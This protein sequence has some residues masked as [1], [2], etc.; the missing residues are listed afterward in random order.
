L[1]LQLRASTIKLDEYGVPVAELDGRTLFHHFTEL[2]WAQDAAS[3]HEKSVWALASVLWDPI[4]EDANPEGET[5]HRLNYMREKRRKE[6]LSKFLEELVEADADDHV[7]KASTLE[8]TAFA[9]LT[10]HRVEQAC[11]ALL[12]SGDF[13]LATLLPMIGGDAISRDL[14]KKQIN[15]WRKKGVL[16]EVPIPIRALYELLSG[17]TCL[18]EGVKAPQEDA[19][20]EFFLTQK[21]G[22]DWKRGFALKLWYG[23]AE[24]D[25]IGSAV[26][27][28]ECEMNQWPGNVPAPLP[29]YHSIS[30]SDNYDTLDIL[31]G[32]LKIYAD[33]KF[34]LEDALSPKS[35]AFSNL[36]YRLSWQ[37]RTIFARKAIRDFDGNVQVLDDGS[38]EYVPGP[39]ADQVTIDFAGGLETGGLWE[40]AIFV[41]LHLIDTDSRE[42]AIRNILGRHLDELVE[43]EGPEVAKKLD[44]LENNLLIPQ[45]WIFEA[46]VGLFP[47]EPC[48]LND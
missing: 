12:E 28:Y 44:F 48:A 11:A 46:R 33:T 42:T 5:D 19:A 8:E 22:L 38:E 14:I 29:W 31:W 23:C 45:K 40:W 3:Q 41:L 9:H 25:G 26:S 16:A 35:I 15:E 30:Q 47:P 43:V 32:L 18:S 34:N 37:L 39:I 20:Q 17:N 2:P 7:H 1:E 27:A 4:E 36:N 24:E 6:K 13:R 21:F 10:A